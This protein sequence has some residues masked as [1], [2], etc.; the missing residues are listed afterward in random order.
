MQHARLNQVKRFFG[1]KPNNAREQAIIQEY[2][3]QQAQIQDFAKAIRGNLG[4][5][6]K[7]FTPTEN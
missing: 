1:L 7:A 6:V 2:E 3:A 5:K 4:K